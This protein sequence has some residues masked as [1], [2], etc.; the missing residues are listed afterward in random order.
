MAN[1]MRQ[2]HRTASHIV[3]IVSF[4]L[5][6]NGMLSA[7]TELAPVD[8]KVYPFLKRMQVLG[9]IPEYN[10]SIL[11]ISRREVADLLK[12]ISA[13]SGLSSTDQSILHD[14]VTEFSFDMSRTDSLSYG[15][16]NDPSLISIFNDERQKYFF[17]STDHDVSFFLDG[18]A[19]LSQRGYHG[20]RYNSSLLLG[21]LGARFRGTLYEN[22]GFYLKLSNGQAFNSMTTKDR[23]TAALFDPVLRSSQKFLVEDTKNTDFYE[24]YIR[25]Q[26]DRNWLAL[27][28]GRERVN[29]SFGYLD[30]LFFSNNNVPFDFA[31][32]DVRIHSLQYSFLYGNLLGDSLGRPLSNKLIVSH[33]L[34]LNFSNLKFGV[35]EAIIMPERSISFTYLNPVSFLV[36][37]DLSLSSSQTTNSLLGFDVEYV[38]VNDIALQA[39]LLVDDVNFATISKND[40]TSN[41]NKFAYQFG[42]D[43]QN[44]LTIPNLALTAE[45]TW[46]GPFVYAHRSNMATFTHW[47]VSLG[48]AIPPNS[49]EIALR[50]SYDISSRLKVSGTYKSQRSAKGLRFSPKGVLLKNYGGELLRGDGDYLQVNSF[51]QGDRYSQRSMI[52][53]IR[54]EPIRQYVLSLNVLLLT[55]TDQVLNKEYVDTIMNLTAE[56]DF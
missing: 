22:V 36:S 34:S 45:Y 1:S 5:I 55:Y 7:Q 3:L 47:K 35:F 54:F 25:F 48:H 32:F 52:G 21:E 26:T 9:V 41:D 28:L 44:A 27:T 14:L 40:S 29:A 50:M 13:S 43:W 39:T 23:R 42:V 30:K 12:R 37:A 17:L 51:L 38:P 15:F 56:I 10:S 33:R 31:K 6:S 20:D 16:V 49:D 53:D 19:S 18:F 46:I 11:P 8:H 4:L 2:F 24:G